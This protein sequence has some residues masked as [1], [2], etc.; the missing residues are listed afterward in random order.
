MDLLDNLNSLYHFN[1][2]KIAKNINS[3]EIQE[4]GTSILESASNLQKM[5]ILQLV[6]EDNATI[7]SNIYEEKER[8][9][10]RQLLKGTDT[11]IS[12]IT[13]FDTILLQQ[14]LL[15]YLGNYTKEMKSTVLS[16]EVEY[17]IGKK[18]SDILIEI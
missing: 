12:E 15:K 8:V 11:K 5:G 13:W 6:I 1:I 16:Y 7:S 9:S 14:Y 4:K 2:L 17:L 10:K 3:Q 18:E